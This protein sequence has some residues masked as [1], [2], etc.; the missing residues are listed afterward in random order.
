MV[1]DRHDDLHL[2]GDP[3]GYYSAVE[4][5]MDLGSIMRKAQELGWD[6]R[7]NE[8]ALRK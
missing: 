1:Y 3:L 4:W 5:T 8:Q 7:I 6:P 2:L